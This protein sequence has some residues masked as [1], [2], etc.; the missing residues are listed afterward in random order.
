MPELVWEGK[1]DKDGRKAGPLR[2][3]LPFQTVETINESVQ[4]R[5]RALDLFSHYGVFSHREMHSRYEIALE[6][7]VMSIN[8][9][10][11][12][13]LEMATT[14]ILPAALRYQGEVASSVNATKAAGVDNSEQTA[15]LKSLTTT[16]GEFQKA[17]AKLDSALGHH[18]D[19]D[20]L[21]HAKHARDEVLTAMLEVRKLGD[22]LEGVVAADLW[23]LPTYREM[24]FIK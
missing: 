3:A 21:S 14:M 23:P 13:T 17:T 18:A 24:L 11:R 15:L 7:Y 2:V 10:A 4:E 9:E 16:I 22:T 1:Y 12:L 20:A 6:H 8:V 19:G 5:Q